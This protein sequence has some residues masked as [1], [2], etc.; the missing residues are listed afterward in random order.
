MAVRECGPRSG[1]KPV[2]PDAL[3]GAVEMAEPNGRGVP[4]ARR[5]ASPSGVLGKC[6]LSFGKPKTQ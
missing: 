6:G 3:A 4:D 1:P 5:T 2:T